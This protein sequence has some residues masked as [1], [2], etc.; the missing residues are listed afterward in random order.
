MSRG[1]V[2]VLTYDPAAFLEESVRRAQSVWS[3]L[4]EGVEERVVEGL[5]RDLADGTWDARHGA[6]RTQPTFDGGLRLVIAELQ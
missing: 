3:K 6:L 2:V 1:S 4:P 5:R